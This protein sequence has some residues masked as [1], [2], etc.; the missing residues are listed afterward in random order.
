VLK[1]ISTSQGN[2]DNTGYCGICVRNFTDCG[3]QLGL[4]VQSV[5]RTSSCVNAGWE[6]VLVLVLDAAAFD[7]ENEDEDEEDF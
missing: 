2:F 4:R 6:I 3:P 1:P 5:C 7:Y